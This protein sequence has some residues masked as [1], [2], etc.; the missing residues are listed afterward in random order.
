M[1]LS[2]GATRP[3]SPRMNLSTSGA[4]GKA[5]SAGGAVAPVAQPDHDE[6][7]DD[8]QGP[9]LQQPLRQAL[10]ADGEHGH[11]DEGKS[12]V[13]RRPVG[14][15]G[16]HEPYQG[17]DGEHERAEHVGKGEGASVYDSR[18]PEPEL[19]G[20]DES[21]EGGDEAD[22]AGSPVHGLGVEVVRLVPVG[23]THLVASPA[24]YVL[25]VP[26]AG[27][28]LFSREAPAKALAQGRTA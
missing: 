17:V 3:S 12:R 11:E 7:K 23:L 6:Q 13:P 18:G 21:D 26:P 15:V 5:R 19:A 25:P 8:T 10:A 27:R 24:A 4:E 9:E 22:S 2:T 28:L 1:A 14:E 20:S 16:R